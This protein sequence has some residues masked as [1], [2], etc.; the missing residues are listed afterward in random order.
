MA[1]VI[2]YEEKNGN[3]THILP[4]DIDARLCRH[5]NVPQTENNFFAGWYD[6]VAMR[7]CMGWS[8]ERIIQMCQERMIE[9]PQFEKQ[10]KANMIICQLFQE[11]Y[12][13][14]VIG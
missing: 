9:K 3:K 12:T 8:Y 4:D 6:V 14:I 5:F 10:Y 13:Y 2:F 11:W 7:L 1:E